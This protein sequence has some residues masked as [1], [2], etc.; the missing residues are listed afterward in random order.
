MTTEAALAL[1]TI[2]AFEAAARERRARKAEAALKSSG[3]SSLEVEIIKWVS[4]GK[5]SLDISQVMGLGT[6]ASVEKRITRALFKIGVPTRAAAVS[7]A[8]RNGVIE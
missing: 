6:E 3:L 7:W 2:Q 4:L 1:E 5:S 8:F